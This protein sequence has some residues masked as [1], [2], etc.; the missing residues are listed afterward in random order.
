M[1]QN[2]V[3]ISCSMLPLLAR[4]PA[5]Y[6]RSLNAPPYPTEQQSRMDSGIRV[7]K[8]LAGEIVNEATEQERQ[9][10]AMLKKRL[11]ERLAKLEVNFN[12]KL[13]VLIEYPL[14]LSLNDFSLNGKADV[15]A[16]NNN[17]VAVFD[18]KTRSYSYDPWQIYA[19]LIAFL[20]ERKLDPTEHMCIVGF[21]MP[22]SLV[23]ENLTAQQLS[24]IKEQIERIVSGAAEEEP[25]ARPGDHCRIC[26]AS[27]VC[28]DS[29]NRLAVTIPSATQI[30]TL[31]NQE[32]GMFYAKYLALASLGNAL[33]E[34]IIKRIQNGETINGFRIEKAIRRKI[35][36]VSKLYERLQ[37]LGISADEFLQ[38]V[39][40]SLMTLRQIAASK[41]L[42]NEVNQIIDEMA[43][44]EEY[45]K[46]V[47]E[48]DE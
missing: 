36:D 35:E 3:Y 22:T 7:H 25:I 8:L 14:T 16:Y 48:S 37:P 45:I 32:L 20:Q 6:K 23:E 18:Y 28:Q 26:K 38:A 41:G 11:E 12:E 9:L 15:I 10:A 17:I 2:N 4:C 42:K 47:R 33:K 39:D 27:P 43:T 1:K 13:N 40:V 46:L 29:L 34:E 24:T 31:S 21:C 19:Y 30:S 44:K 5:A